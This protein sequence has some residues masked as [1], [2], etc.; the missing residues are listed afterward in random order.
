VIEW[1]GPNS[2]KAS[3]E[4]LLDAWATGGDVTAQVTTVNA[5]SPV[6]P[7]AE[8][9]VVY[10]SGVQLIPATI[11]WVIQG[12]TWTDQMLNAA[13]RI[14]RVTVAFDLLQWRQGDVVVRN[15]PAKAAAVLTKT[16]RAKA[17]TVTVKRGDTLSSLAAKYLGSASSWQKI[18]TLNGLRDPNHLKVGQVLK[19][20]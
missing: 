19:L 5:L 1:L 6:A 16:T 10:V 17:R 8:T 7:T 3:V 13:G 20:P 2:H 4:L 12:V 18:A 15:S 11:P 9:P 14:A